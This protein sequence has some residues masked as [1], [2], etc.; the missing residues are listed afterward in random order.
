MKSIFEKNLGKILVLCL[1]LISS[2]SKSIAGPYSVKN[3]E[4]SNKDGERP[5]PGPA[6]AC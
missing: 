4:I 6:C 2:I 3:I 5:R 1:I